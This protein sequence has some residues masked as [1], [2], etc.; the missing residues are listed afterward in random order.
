MLRIAKWAA[1]VVALGLMLGLAVKVKAEDAKATGTV[2]GTVVDKDGKAVANASVGVFTADMQHKHKADK[3]AEAAEGDK[4]KADKAGKEKG[5]KPKPVG[6]AT[7]DAEGKFTIKDVPAGDYVVRV[8]VKGQ[9]RAV[10]K[11]SVKAGE[12]ATADLKLGETNKK[13]KAA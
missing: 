4:D 7:T 1:P 12:T 11:V 8:N 6:E 9:G 3:Q 13:P 10:Q 2:S 5:D